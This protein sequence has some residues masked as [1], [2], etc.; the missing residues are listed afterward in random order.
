MIYSALALAA[1]KYWYYLYQF[2]LKI[3][4]KSNKIQLGV[5]IYF[6]KYLKYVFE[7]S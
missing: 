4:V 1:N 5:S 7:L 3:L 6:E 2:C